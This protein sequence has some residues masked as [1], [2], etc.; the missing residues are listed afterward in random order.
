M[1]YPLDWFQRLDPASKLVMISASIPLAVCELEFRVGSKKRVLTADLFD[2]MPDAAAATLCSHC[3]VQHGK[4]EAS[5][6]LW[7]S[8]CD[9][10]AIFDQAV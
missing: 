7:C 2:C 1:S 10:G 6:G 9:G 4:H 5:H 3:S 8:F